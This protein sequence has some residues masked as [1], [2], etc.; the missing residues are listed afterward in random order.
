M[1]STT[2]QLKYTYPYPTTYTHR[3]RALA[4]TQPALLV[5]LPCLLGPVLVKVRGGSPY[6]IHWIAAC[7]L[8]PVTRLIDSID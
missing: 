5:A 7:L 4:I 3:H 2:P 8:R 1:P 6:N